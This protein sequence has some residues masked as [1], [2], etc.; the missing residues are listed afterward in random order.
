MN[1][2]KSTM[3]GC[4]PVGRPAR[5][6]GL[7]AVLCERACI[8]TTPSPCAARAHRASKHPIGKMEGGGDGKRRAGRDRID[9]GR[10]PR[11]G[12]SIVINSDVASATT[13]Q[14]RDRQS[15]RPVPERS[16]Q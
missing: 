3:S 14:A 5:S 13:D 10:I 4:Y 2:G 11:G 15:R 7:Y 16:R 9:S 6:P 12:P 1:S 8:R